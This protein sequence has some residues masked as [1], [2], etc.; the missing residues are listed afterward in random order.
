MLEYCAIHEKEIF[1]FRII[2]DDF[3]GEW[4]FGRK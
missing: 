1:C 4:S 3:F 2:S